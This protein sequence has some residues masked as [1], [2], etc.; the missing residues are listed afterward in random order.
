MSDA[1]TILLIDD[2]QDFLFMNQTQLEAAGYQVVTADTAK[3]GLSKASELKPDLVV[4]DL[5]M[6][7]RDA[8][9]T[10]C[11]NLKKRFP[12]MP[13][14]MCSNVVGETGLGFDAGTEEEQ[15]WIKAD[16]MLHKPI[17]FEQLQHEIKRLLQ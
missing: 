5:M 10:L 2:D 7:E 17:R 16:V 11:Y 15:S 13:V 12:E 6:E 14:V 4:A 3:E 1:K 9:F 8:G